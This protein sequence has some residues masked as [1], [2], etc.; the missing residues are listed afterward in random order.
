MDA[1]R[2]PSRP[3]AQPKHGT[4]DGLLR[5]HDLAG[6]HGET[7]ARGVVDVGQRVGIEDVEAAFSAMEAG[8]VLR[9]VVVLS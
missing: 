9:S 5:L 8:K 4:G 6:A 7:D 3:P 2:A 1:M